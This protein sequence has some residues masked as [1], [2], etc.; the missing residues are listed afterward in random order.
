M[1]L[2]SAGLR[3]LEPA[4]ERAILV[5]V[6]APRDPE[7]RLRDTLDELGELV[8]SAGAGVLES[9]MI[10]MVRPQAAT[11][12]GKG[13][14]EEL[15]GVVKEREAT[16]VVFDDEL[17]PAQARTLAEAMNVRV[18]D[19]TQ[20]ILD[21]FA[22]RAQ[23]AEGRLQV[24]LAQLQYLLPRLRGM[25]AGMMRQK[26]G[27]GLRGPGEQ[28]L[29]LDRRRVQI[30]IDYLSAQLEDVRARRE[31]LRRGRRR[32]GWALAGLVG[33]TN[34][35]K[36][37]LLNALS[38]AD[39]YADDR[40]F[41]TLDPTTR[42]IELPNH[43]PALLTDTVGF[44]RKL[45]HRLVEAFKATLEEILYAD[46]LV[47]V[48]DA[49]HPL[50]DAQIDAVLAVLQEIGAAEKPVFAA[51]NKMDVPGARERAGRLERRF[52]RSVQVS[53]RT[54][55]GLDALRA[56]IA[57]H[58]RGRMTE[59][60]L[61]LPLGEGRIPALI[62]DN[63]RILSESY[64]EEGHHLRASLSARL[65]SRVKPYVVRKDKDADADAESPREDGSVPGQW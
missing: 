47:H 8:E 55:E 21:I 60:H 12:I 4:V 1:D 65:L 50:A 59:V 19:R 7:W 40:L 58:V 9:R 38:G 33:Y 44:I 20:V 28:Q 56:E 43:E 51:M 30:R 22:R 27:I 53:A 13:K 23:T 32:H 57:D 31:E 29:E 2:S 3:N 46:V 16:L 64:T 25:W 18:L 54:G 62:R 42:R 45:P 34:A 10:K 36:S 17:S 26:G 5:G 37:T 41:A 14:V 24:E 39:V 15:A 48:V 6:H 11:F 52:K 49:S 63:G 35:G 61:C